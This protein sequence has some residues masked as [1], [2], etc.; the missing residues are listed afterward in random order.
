MNSSVSQ[1]ISA[2]I[3]VLTLLVGGALGW[4]SFLVSSKL[5]EDNLTKELQHETTLAARQIEFQSRIEGGT[6]HAGLPAGHDL[7]RQR[8]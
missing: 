2:S 8:R 1:R 4:G 6:I 5:V 7:P 3:L